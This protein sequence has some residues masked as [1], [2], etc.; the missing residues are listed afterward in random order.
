MTA[1]IWFAFA[2]TAIF[3]AALPSPL[4]NLTASYALQR[5]RKTALAT[6]PGVVAGLATAFLIAAIPLG[7]VAQFLPGAL[8]PL[9]WLGISYLMLYALWS[10]QDPRI[11]GPAADNDN[12]PE[13]RFTRIFI[14]MFAKAVFALRYVLLFAALLS[15][16]L[17]SSL[18]VVPQILEMQAIFLLCV[19]ASSSIHIFFPHRV[20]S[21]HK[22]RPALDPASRKPGTH[23]ISRRAVSAGYR[24][25]AA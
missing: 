20:V 5:G 13:K 17:D 19:A 16:F 15:Q 8:G 10:F 6:L 21:R 7:L 22:R 1:D 24:R 2:A 11:A 23:F 14:Y 18:E 12:L 9:S 4:A 25:I 3:L